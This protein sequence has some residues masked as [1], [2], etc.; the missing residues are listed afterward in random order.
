MTPR[1][2]HFNTESLLICGCCACGV[3]GNALALFFKSTGGLC[4]GLWFWGKVWTL[5]AWCELRD[6]FR[7]FRL[8]RIAGMETDGAPFRPE[9]GKT[10]ADFYRT[11][12]IRDDD[13]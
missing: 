1:I 5:V 11:M 10:L 8:D 13:I 9:R 2:L 7:M 4:L 6:D 3:V 12:E